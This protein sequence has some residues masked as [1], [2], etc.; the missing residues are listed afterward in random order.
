MEYEIV[1]FWH[2]SQ[3]N[4]LHL[5]TSVFQFANTKLGN[6]IGEDSTQVA[7]DVFILVGAGFS[8]VS[9]S[10]TQVKAASAIL[11]AQRF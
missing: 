1:I 8:G 6:C 11:A 7:L 2:V 3:N 9:F 5:G 4:V 10:I